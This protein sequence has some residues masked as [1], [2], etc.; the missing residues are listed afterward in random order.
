MAESRPQWIEKS[1]FNWDNITSVAAYDYFTSGTLQDNGLAELQIDILSDGNFYFMWRKDGGENTKMDF[2]INEDRKIF[3]PGSRDC[4]I[5]KLTSPREVYPVKKGDTLRWLF[6]T[7][8]LGHSWT[9]TVAIPTQSTIQSQI[10]PPLEL[11]VPSGET[12]INETHNY[13]NNKNI[14]ILA[15]QADKS[16]P[17][18]IGTVIIFTAESDDPNNNDLEFKYYLNGQAISDWNSD[19]I[20]IWNTTDNDIG[21]NQIEI[22]SRSKNSGDLVGSDSSAYLP[23]DIGKVIEDG[24]NLQKSYVFSPHVNF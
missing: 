17:Q 2:Y 21:S 3:C 20:W 14:S 24:E 12:R 10:Q 18:E 15:I 19:R 5:S 8:N 1:Q 13:K 7:T 16:S 4:P 22:R 11:L 9:T 23:Y 6:T